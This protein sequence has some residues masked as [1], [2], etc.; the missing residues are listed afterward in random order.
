MLSRDG[1]SFGTMFSLPQG[2][3]L[4][5]KSDDHP[6]VLNGETA[7]EFRH[8]L[9]ALYALYVSH[10][11]TVNWYSNERLGHPNCET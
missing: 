5:G 11:Y 1:S 6:I 4:E 9:S 7:S 10:S 8:F 2:G 3:T